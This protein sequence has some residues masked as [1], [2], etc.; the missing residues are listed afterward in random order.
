M[1]LNEKGRELADYLGTLPDFQIVQGANYT[2][3]GAIFVDAM[4]QAGANYDG[5]KDRVKIVLNDKRANTTSGFVDM[6]EATPVNSLLQWKGKK[7]GWVESITRYFKARGV[8][9]KSDLKAWLEIPSNAIDLYLEPG[10][11]PK[12]VDYLK[13]LAGI[14]NVAIDRHWETCLGLAGISY[15]SYFEAKQIAIYAAQYMRIDESSL[16]T[17]VWRYIRAKKLTGTQCS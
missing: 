2:S 7:P 17:S 13:K 16:D 11:G 12:T 15:G 10:M 6:L 9:T 3:M 8:E 1:G 5:V 4:L 14:P